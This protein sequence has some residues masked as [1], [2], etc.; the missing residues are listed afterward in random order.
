[1]KESLTGFAPQC[2]AHPPPKPP[3]ALRSGP[4][5]A[6]AFGV[7]AARCAAVPAGGRRAGG[8][9]A[10]ARGAGANAAAGGAPC[11]RSPPVPWAALKNKPARGPAGQRGKTTAHAV[12]AK[13]AGLAAHV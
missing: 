12:A 6:P 4:P 8:R 5:R 7:R 13:A 11:P 1:M 10:L 2:S 9:S 3:P